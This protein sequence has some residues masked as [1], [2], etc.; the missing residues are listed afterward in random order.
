M[1]GW[2]TMAKASRGIVAVCVLAVL[3]LGL[4]PAKAAPGAN[5]D[6]SLCSPIPKHFKHPGE[7]NQYFP[8]TSAMDGTLVGPDGDE[9]HGLKITVGGNVTVSGIKTT[10]VNEF[11]W[12]EMIP[13]GIW[14]FTSE[15]P[16][17][18]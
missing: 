17:E 3:A 12:I 5:L 4:S 15:T 11:E 14:D 9:I 8:L 18:D 2:R 10:V 7:P 6:P 1:K 16:V 13:D